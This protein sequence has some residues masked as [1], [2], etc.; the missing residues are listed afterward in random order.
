M[1]KFDVFCNPPTATSQ[2]KG[3]MRCGNGIRFYTKP[4]VRR[5]QADLTALL[6]VYTPEKP[7]EGALF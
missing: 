6:G 1:V 7:L 2:Q 4:H 3:A 5:A